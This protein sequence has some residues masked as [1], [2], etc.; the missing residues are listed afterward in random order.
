[1]NKFVL[2]AL[3]LTAASTPSLAGEADWLMLDRDME[4]L[5]SSLAQNAGG[6]T[7][8]VSGFLRSS[9]TSPLPPRA[10]TSAA[11]PSTTRV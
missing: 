1:M 5:T 4:S 10:M 9:Y 11:S 2:S 6:S 3:A 8:A 7:V